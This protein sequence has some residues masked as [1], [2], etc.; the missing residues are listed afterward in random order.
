MSLLP[1]PSGV[2]WRRKEEKRSSKRR[3][4]LVAL[5][6][7]L[8]LV[9]SWVTRS[10]SFNVMINWDLP[11][12]TCTLSTIK[13]GKT[14]VNDVCYD[15]V[16]MGE[17]RGIGGKC[18]TETKYWSR[19]GHTIVRCFVTLRA[20]TDGLTGRRASARRVHDRRCWTKH[21]RWRL[22]FPLPSPLPFLLAF[23]LDLLLSGAYITVYNV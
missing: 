14:R 17:G 21:N 12:N 10:T 4:V 5:S 22:R 19:L 20:E 1:F 9:T 2:R 16:Y 6:S 23:H 18:L 3:W 11:V 7:N 15:T 8:H 13:W